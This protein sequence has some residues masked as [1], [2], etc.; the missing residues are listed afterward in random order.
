MLNAMCSVRTQWAKICFFVKSIS[1]KF[2]EIDFTKKVWAH[3]AILSWWMLWKKYCP[4]PKWLRTRT[5]KW[6]TKV[7]IVK[8]IKMS[9]QKRKNYAQEIHEPRWR[10][11]KKRDLHYY[12]IY[13][14]KLTGF[15]LY[16]PLIFLNANKWYKFSYSIF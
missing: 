11:N 12:S 13:L 10:R 14:K 9:M 4:P 16:V 6:L 2:R 7:R 8:I 1:R 15:T 3:S 5:S